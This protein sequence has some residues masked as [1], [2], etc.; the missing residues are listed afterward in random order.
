LVLA[1]SQIGGLAAISAKLVD[2][3][4][5]DEEAEQDEYKI[6]D[7]ILRSIPVIRDRTDRSKYVKPTVAAG[8]RAFSQGALDVS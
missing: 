2:I 6:S 1:Q 4:L 7:Y 5:E 8:S 3:L